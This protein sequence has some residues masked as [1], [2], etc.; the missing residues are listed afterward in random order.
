VEKRKKKEESAASTDGT[1][2]GELLDAFGVGGA[3][4]EAPRE[5]VG[6]GAVRYPD[7]EGPFRRGGVGAAG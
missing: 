1:V 6:V 7:D 5:G 3:H 4:G 2:C